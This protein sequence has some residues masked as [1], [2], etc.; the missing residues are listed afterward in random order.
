MT[1]PSKSKTKY[2]EV[3]SIPDVQHDPG[4]AVLSPYCYEEVE[5]H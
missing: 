4:A 1:D 2:N 5:A 3:M